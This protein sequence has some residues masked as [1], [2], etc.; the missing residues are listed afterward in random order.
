M[1]T[2][3][4]LL[5]A[6]TEELIALCKYI[7]ESTR[8]DII[9]IDWYHYV[10]SVHTLGMFVDWFLLCYWNYNKYTLSTC[11]IYCLHIYTSYTCMLC[12]V[13]RDVY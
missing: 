3:P 7:N 5:N 10:C 6:Y 2:L 12:G 9:L 8:L 13:S 1:Q 11:C 4:L